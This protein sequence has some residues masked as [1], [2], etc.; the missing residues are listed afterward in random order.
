L[1]LVLLELLG[2]GLKL[3]LLRKGLA[4]AGRCKP[5]GQGC[6]QARCSCCNSHGSLNITWWEIHPQDVRPVQCQ[7][8]RS[9]SKDV[10]NGC[11]VASAQLPTAGGA[12][13]AR[14]GRQGLPAHPAL[15]GAP[16]VKN[17]DAPRNGK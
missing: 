2:L 16:Q 14:D 13:I 7:R 12:A 5:T 4:H 9:G 6:L 1:L 8:M 11:K 3:L 15:G 10:E 17:N